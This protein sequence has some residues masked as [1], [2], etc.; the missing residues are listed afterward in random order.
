[1]PR[2]RVGHIPPVPMGARPLGLLPSSMP[3]HID[4]VL[5]PADPVGLAQFA[6]AVSD[7]AS[8]RYRQY[9]ARGA[10]VR[11]FGASPATIAAL[12]AALRSA[13]LTSLHVGANG[14]FVSV[15]TT[16]GRAGLALGVSLRRFRLP[17][18]RTVYE[19]D[20]APLLPITVA[21][22]VAAVIG[23][24]DLVEARPMAVR[25]ATAS[26][27]AGAPRPRTTGPQPCVQAQTTSAYTANQLAAAY[28]FTGLYAQGDLGSGQQV[29]LAEFATFNPSDVATYQSCYG[30][31]AAVRTIT[32]VPGAGSGSNSVEPTLDIEDVAGLAPG[33]AIDVYEGPATPS[34][35]YETY[36]DIVN[37]DVAQVVSTSWGFCEPALM[38]GP[39]GNQ[40]GY[41][42]AAAEAGVFEQAAAQGQSVLAA[43]GDS[44]STGCW[45]PG[46][47]NDVLAA[48]DPSTQ[49]DVTA[50][51]GTS[52]SLSSSGQ[53]TSEVVWNDSGSANLAGG[54]GISSNW[55]MPTWQAQSPAW[56][57][58]INQYSSASPCGAPTGSYCREVPDV[59]ASA[60]PTKGYA[61]YY[62]GPGAPASGWGAIG[63]TSASSP[64]WAALVALANA[65]NS[66]ATSGG[67]ALGALD[68]TLYAVAG[69][70]SANYA[71]GFYDVTSGNNDYTPSGYTGGLYPAT[72]GYDMA[73]GLGTP[74]AVTAGGGLVAE[75][76]GLPVVRS[77]SPAG[78]PESGGT[79]VNIAGAGF[80]TTG[81]TA[82]AFGQS[83]ATSVSC[84]SATT[85]R[86]TS[87][88]GSGRV[89]LQVTVAGERSLTSAAD[90]FSY[91]PAPTISSI[92]PSS[93]SA[94]GGNQVT[95]YGTDLEASSAPT[96]LSVGG[97]PVAVSC[98]SSQCSYT[99]PAGSG[100]EA[101]TVTTPG[102]SASVGYTY[103]S[104]T[105]PV[106]PAPPGPG[107]PGSPGYWMVASD[108]G[109]FAFNA[110]FAGSMGGQ[111][112]S[113]PI[114]G[115]AHA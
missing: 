4:V 75:L 87:P 96:T 20:A 29:A 45:A 1:M 91:T 35:I 52:L 33:A 49:P 2:V 97:T 81:G 44:G 98:A 17:A 59:S 80:S 46:S 63:G 19:P 101:V 95:I 42:A 77:I 70:S 115:M 8:P 108:G 100:T 62:T 51:G 72:V 76:C 53:R 6:D 65:S 27:G 66:C 37:Q 31:S 83:P 68:P 102:G 107:T 54:G 24:D 109:I 38:S 9:L 105:S 85:C 84:S 21:P 28:G 60:D 23:L 73:S 16:A 57:G 113:A 111:H 12:S 74:N 30:T 88:P 71:A 90:I 3:L 89:D 47:T 92:S 103:S 106:G 40:Q 7:P 104:S 39:S 5:E 14:Q 61:I 110:P 82:V 50:V 112:L 67:G 22:Q 79:V 11:R 58:V 48:V 86:A 114:V 41:S 34:G 55:T 69:S 93:G 10:F 36:A 13:G 56:L 64:L 15:T 18:G 26:A 94:S 43:A 78:G 25:P 32:A 99:A